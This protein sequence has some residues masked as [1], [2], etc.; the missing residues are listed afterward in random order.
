M[1]PIEGV[2][3]DRFLKEGETI[4]VGSLQLE[5]IHTPG[6]SPGSVC[7]YLTGT[8]HSDFWRYSISRQHRAVSISPPAIQKQ[9][10][11]RL[12]KLAKLPSRNA[13]HPRPWR[14][15]RRSEKRDCKA[16]STAED[17]FVSG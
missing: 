15:Y 1:F 13:R 8:R 4:Q 7:F 6:H 12:R 9:M 2:V 17:I 5:V 3:P 16:G 11:N 14:R 10:W